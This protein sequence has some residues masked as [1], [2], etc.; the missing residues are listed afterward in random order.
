MYDTIY[1]EE[2][3]RCIIWNMLREEWSFY[4][5]LTEPFVRPLL[6]CLLGKNGNNWKSLFDRMQRE[7]H[8]D[9]TILES[10]VNFK[11]FFLTIQRKGV[12]LGF[13]KVATCHQLL[14]PVAE[15]ELSR[16]LSS[17]VFNGRCKICCL[18][19]SKLWL[20]VKTGSGNWPPYGNLVL[21]AYH[22]LQAILK[23]RYGGQRL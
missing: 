7:V 9:S 5:I 17:G 22:L 3:Y 18:F 15:S 6:L 13:H 4:L 19:L 16:S 11:L 10:S 20:M 12:T 21:F 8:W 1:D 23:D 14:L 2:L